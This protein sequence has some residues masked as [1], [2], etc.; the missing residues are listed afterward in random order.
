MKSTITVAVAMQADRKCR[1][2]TAGKV[3]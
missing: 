2:I 3:Y 1:N